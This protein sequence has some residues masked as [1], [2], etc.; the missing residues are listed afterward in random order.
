MIGIYRQNKFCYVIT[1]AI[2]NECSAYATLNTI[3]CMKYGISTKL[4]VNK[5][6]RFQ[7]PAAVTI[8]RTEQNLYENGCDCICVVYPLQCIRIVAEPKIVYIIVYLNG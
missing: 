3:N 1:N 8:S 5:M 2:D 7:K 6:Q 4:E